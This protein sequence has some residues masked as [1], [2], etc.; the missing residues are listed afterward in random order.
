MSTITVE[1][2]GDRPLLMH[3]GQMADPLNPWTKALKKVTSKRQK[4]DEDHIEIMRIEF[5]GGLY[6]DKKI[7]VYIP[8][9]NIEGCIWEG[10]KIKKRGTQ[11]RQGM[12]CIEDR[13]ALRYPGP[14]TAEALWDLDEYRDVR[15]VKIGGTSTTMRCRPMFREWSLAFTLGYYNDVIDPDGIRQALDDA[16]RRMGL[17]DYNQR[18]GRFSVTQWDVTP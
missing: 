5:M 13:V 4:T 17:G 9:I 16:G 10:G 15:G 6:F 14:R 2:T 7:G 8:G 11:I 18:F 1:I 12:T 3:N